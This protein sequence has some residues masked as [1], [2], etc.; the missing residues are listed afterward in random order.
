M[1]AEEKKSFDT[2][3]TKDAKDAKENKSLTAKAAKVA[4]DYLYELEGAASV[5]CRPP[6]VP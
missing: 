6:T 1:D 2:K 5:V 4:K 3:D